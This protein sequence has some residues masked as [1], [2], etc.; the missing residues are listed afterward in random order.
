MNQDPYP[1]LEMHKKSNRTGKEIIR[2][3][4]VDYDG[5]TYDG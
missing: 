2:L 4:L 5:G 3:K 1:S